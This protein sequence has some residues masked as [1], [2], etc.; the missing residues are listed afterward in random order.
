MG[1]HIFLTSFVYIIQIILIIGIILHKLRSKY[2]RK[3][4]VEFNAEG[5]MV[6]I[7]G[8]QYKITGK[9]LM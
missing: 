4:K 3:H 5:W 7:I 2:M 6:P 9:S 8:R 1:P